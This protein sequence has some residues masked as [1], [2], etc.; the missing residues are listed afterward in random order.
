MFQRQTERIKRG[1]AQARRGDDAEPQFQPDS[2]VAG[3]S[4]VAAIVEAENSLE[5]EVH[6]NKDELKTKLKEI[7]R[8]KSDVFNSK[9]S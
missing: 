9:K 7:L 4:V 2:L 8:E 6:D 3:A 5:I 1:K